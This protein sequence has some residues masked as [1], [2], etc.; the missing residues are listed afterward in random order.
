[1]I[2]WSI[3]G[4]DQ[5]NKKAKKLEFVV[6]GACFWVCSG[7]LAI[8][9]EGCDMIQYPKSKNIDIEGWLRWYFWLIEGLGSFFKKWDKS[10]ILDLEY[11]LGGVV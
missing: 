1:M 4:F 11:I 2:F 5:G 7:V 10:L 9:G 3:Q 6:D 8:K